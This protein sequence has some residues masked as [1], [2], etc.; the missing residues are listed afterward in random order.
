[1]ETQAT[2]AV[3]DSGSLDAPRLPPEILL[4]VAKHIE[5]GTAKLKRFLVANK[6][7]YELLLPHFL[8][9]L[10]LDGPERLAALVGAFSKNSEGRNLF[11]YLKKFYFTHCGSVDKELAT[12]NGH[13][14]ELVGQ[15]S[16]L[17]SFGYYSE[18][19]MDENETAFKLC[20][21]HS[22]SLTH[23]EVSTLDAYPIVVGG[24]HSLPRLRMLDCYG[25]ISVAFANS[26]ADGSPELESIRFETRSYLKDIER[27][28]W[29]FVSK[30]K[31]FVTDEGIFI[32]Q[33][34]AFPEF[35]PTKIVCENDDWSYAVPRDFFHRIAHIRNLRELYVSNMHTHLLLQGIP[36]H[37]ECLKIGHADLSVG[38]D[39]LMRL[40]AL[41]TESKLKI[42]KMRLGGC[43]ASARIQEN[44][45]AICELEFWKRWGAEIDCEPVEYYMPI[46]L[47]KQLSAK[48]ADMVKYFQPQSSYTP[49]HV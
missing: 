36:P 6:T 26:I 40:H 47:R 41:V 15:A 2:S 13:L 39:H 7:T 14:V 1:M 8:S 25:P 42:V 45:D 4:A 20:G 31:E 35:Q 46:E 30:I 27:L 34:S 32:V 18:A 43:I 12:I 3:A 21:L 17:E 23:L 29:R 24:R 37:L 9:D 16:N 33:F 49:I 5:P 44:F 22:E 38:R 48:R 19:G 11:K 28:S 10:R